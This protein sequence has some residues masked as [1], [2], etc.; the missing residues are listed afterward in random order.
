MD[1][2]PVKSDYPFYIGNEPIIVIF[3]D[4]FLTYGDYIKFKVVCISKFEFISYVQEL[5]SWYRD[6]VAHKFY[7]TG[8]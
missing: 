3:A 5:G 2:L 6:S 4:M 1:G 7:H 8:F